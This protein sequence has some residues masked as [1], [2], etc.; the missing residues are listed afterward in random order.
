LQE[1]LTVLRDVAESLRYAHEQGVIHRDIKPENVL[2]VE[3]RALV[4]DFGIARAAD[5][6]RVRADPD[7]G[8]TQAGTSLGTPT[9]MSPEQ[10]AGD[11]KLS[12]RADLYSLGV[13]GYEMLAGRPPF[14]GDT[15]QE[16]L[17]AKL[18]SAA[19][20]LLEFRSDTPTWL[21]GMIMQCL[22]RDPARRP[23]TAG[24]VTAELTA[25]RGA[26]QEKP[27]VVREII[28]GLRRVGLPATLVSRRFWTV[29]AVAAAALAAAGLW[30]MTGADVET[31]D[32]NLVAVLPFRV[33]GGDTVLEEMG[34]GV[35]DLAAIYLTGD[36]GS[37]RAVEPATLFRVREAR[38]GGA[39]DHETDG[40][41]DLALARELGA[42]WVLR[43]SFVGTGDDV[44][45]RAS[46]VPVGGGDAIHASVTGAVDSLLANVPRLLGRLLAQRHGIT[47]DQSGSLTTTSLPAVRAYLVGQRHYRRGEYALAV[48]RFTE[49][50]GID[51]TFALAALGLLMAHEW[52]GNA[53]Y[54][55]TAAAREIAWQNRGRLRA[56]DRALIAAVAGPEGT[57]LS[58]LADVQAAREHAAI[59]APDRFEAWYLLAD[60][61]FHVGALL[62]IDEPLVRS[63]EA[64]GRSL[65]LDP[66]QAGV[67]QHLIQIAAWR[68]D[69]AEVRARWTEYRAAVP[70]PAVRFK[71]EWLVGQLLEDSTLVRSAREHFDGSE[72]AH[73]GIY[74]LV[75]SVALFPEL[76]GPLL[77]LLERAELGVRGRAQREELAELRW[78]L[79]LDAGRP[80]EAHHALPDAGEGVEDSQKLLDELF[81]GA[82][83]VV[84]SREMARM[85]D[86]LGVCAL[87][88]LHAHEARWDSVDGAVERLAGFTGQPGDVALLQGRLCGRLLQAAHAQGTGSPE[89]HRLILAV[90][91]LLLT[92]PHV[93][94]LW[95]NLMVARL[96]EGEGEYARAAAAAGRFRYGLGY[97]HYMAAYLRE[98]GRLA[99]LAGDRER[100]IDRYTRY[101]ALRSDPEPAVADEVARVRRALDSLTASP[102]ALRH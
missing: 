44:L 49:A 75:T 29:T 66:G 39:G 100:A 85:T 72:A 41:G 93:Q 99:A 46:M 25:E 102:S 76:A 59:V 37:L 4:T 78:W 17:A 87:G 101:L 81:W 47:P 14:T 42:G 34:E 65:A 30:H 53:P 2:L 97:P 55:V 52:S 88:L 69:T 62:G 45:M 60:H 15:P 51:S 3:Q 61:L 95:E 96:L 36:Q 58:A 40:D 22:E 56:K 54:T 77:E 38:D 21:A 24:A 90:D 8:L 57:G 92:V 1:V 64:F 32:A 35:V 91:S 31:G 18:T 68:G 70:D 89:A 12:H 79:A 80:Q 43:G 10:A 27:A 28:R 16:I 6:A 63:E 83:R 86:E 13:L 26:A 67:L 9:Y 11:P 5:A 94:L 19:P 23:R 74:S 82:P 71:E 98:G 7:G 33:A 20:D 50:L 84:S 48:D 73:L